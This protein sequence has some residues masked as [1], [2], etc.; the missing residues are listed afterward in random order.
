M[1]LAQPGNLREQVALIK[2]L[3]PDATR[4]GLVFNPN[5]SDVADDAKLAA[6]STGLMAVQAPIK[7]VRDVSKVIRSSMK[8]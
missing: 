3:M 5:Q 6:Q 1:V 2:K 4:F 8:I 7:S